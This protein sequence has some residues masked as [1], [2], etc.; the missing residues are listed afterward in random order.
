M[1]GA[2]GAGGCAPGVGRGVEAVQGRNIPSG[3][4]NC[5]TTATGLNVGCWNK[6]SAPFESLESK[7]GEI[8]ILLIENSL[9]ILAY[10]K[11]TLKQKTLK[12]VWQ[13]LGMN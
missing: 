5:K 6:S 13:F 3:K 4:I 10:V 9:D 2:P 12:K 8:E 11:P 7:V 1:G